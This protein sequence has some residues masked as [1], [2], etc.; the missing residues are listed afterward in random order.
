[1]NFGTVLLIGAIWWS[2]VAFP[3]APK[4]IT[5]NVVL[6]LVIAFAVQ[7]GLMAAFVG[8]SLA[9]RSVRDERVRGGR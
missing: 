6:A 3:E 4:I 8:K 9:A 7:F 5:T 1:M 2:E